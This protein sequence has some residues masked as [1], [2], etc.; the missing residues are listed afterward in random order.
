MIESCGM[1]ANRVF[2]DLDKSLLPFDTVLRV[3]REILSRGLKIRISKATTKLGLSSVA[4]SLMVSCF[5]GMSLNQFRGFFNDL[6]SKFSNELDLMVK[7][8]AESLVTDKVRI[9]IVTG[10]LTPLAEGI[11]ENLGWGQSLGTEVEIR[12]GFL[13]GRLKGPA[14]KGS[15]KL[16]AIK[17][18]LELGDDEFRSCAAVG[19]S[20]SDRYLL[21]KCSMRYFPEN[22]SHRLIKYFND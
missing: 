20:Y 8:W 12:S 5:T 15:Q 7:N 10:S 14:I 13:T 9:H 3:W 1:K 4:K 11:S 19:D 2:V 18:A 6:A 21:E 22:A 17:R 16:E